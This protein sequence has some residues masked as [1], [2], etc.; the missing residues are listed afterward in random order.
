SANPMGQR[1]SSILQVQLDLRI[2]ILSSTGFDTS[3]KGVGWPYLALSP[4][5]E[6]PSVSTRTSFFLGLLVGWWIYCLSALC[7]EPVPPGLILFFGIVLAAL[8]LLVYCKNVST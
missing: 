2:P 5:P 8:R 4:K 6:I 1:P 7:E 3:S